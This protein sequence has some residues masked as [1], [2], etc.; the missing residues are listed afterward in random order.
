MDKIED[1]LT[2][3]MGMWNLV[4][5]KTSVIDIEVP[6]SYFN[7]IYYVLNYLLI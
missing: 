1:W 3:D 2:F 7:N 6:N 4:I 5:F